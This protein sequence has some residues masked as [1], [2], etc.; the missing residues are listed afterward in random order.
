MDY[1]EM[2]K[3]RLDTASETAKKL[4]QE[5]MKIE[6]DYRWQT[7]HG[8]LNSQIAQEIAKKVKE[9]LK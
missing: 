9:I 8:S 5:T 6:K 3:E 7:A 2:I 1:K 4:L